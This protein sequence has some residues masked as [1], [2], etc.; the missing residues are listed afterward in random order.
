MDINKLKY[1]QTLN[2]LANGKTCRDSLIDEMVDGYNIARENLVTRF[3]VMINS[4][5]ALDVFINDS[6]TTTKA[7]IDT[8]KKYS[9]ESTEQES[10]QT[11]PSLIKS[12]DY[13]KIK[14]NETDEYHNYLITSEIKKETRY[15]EG[16]VVKCD[17][18]ILWTNEEK[19]INCPAY[20]RSI[21]QSN[22]NESVSKLY[23][24]T[25][26]KIDLEISNNVLF[27]N[28]PNYVNIKELYPNS[29]FQIIKR[30]DNKIDGLV[31]LTLIKD[32][33]TDD[34]DIL[35]YSEYEDEFGI[36]REGWIISKK[37]YKS[38]IR[39]LTAEDIT[40]EW[41]Y[42]LEVSEVLYVPIENDITESS[43]IK[44]ENCFYKTVK[45][46]KCVNP[47]KRLEGYCVIGLIKNDNQNINIIEESEG[48]TNE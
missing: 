19:E 35:N 14:R 20:S 34:V 48:D 31:E 5:M 33:Y 36:S 12:G 25:D 6:E 41:G 45:F 4:N 37:D 7:I 15:D 39:N 1:Y 40:K 42:D 26:L 9:A 27:S 17:K 44:Y 28:I 29:R 10:I 43:L 18:T 13:I 3:D 46:N 32:I 23:K 8:K 11:Y 2:G 38:C 47:D 16:I 21:N 30:H 24:L 22:T